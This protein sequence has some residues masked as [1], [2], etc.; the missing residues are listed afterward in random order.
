MCRPAPA[1]AEVSETQLAQL[2]ADGHV[3]LEGDVAALCKNKTTLVRVSN[4]DQTPVKLVTFETA[5]ESEL[6]SE[7][8][9]VFAMA[10]SAPR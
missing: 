9:R 7:L 4:L 2:V 3:V 1:G 10:C 8:A 6:G 5:I